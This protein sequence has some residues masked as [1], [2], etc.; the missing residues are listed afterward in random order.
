MKSKY[1]KSV[2]IWKER[3]FNLNEIQQKLLKNYN[4]LAEA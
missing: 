1:K 4:K 2:I 3:V